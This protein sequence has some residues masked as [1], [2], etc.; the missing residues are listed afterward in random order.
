MPVHIHRITI[1]QISEDRNLHFILSSDKRAPED[2]HVGFSQAL[3]KP[4]TILTCAS[5]C[6]KIHTKLHLVEFHCKVTWISK[7]S[8]AFILRAQAHWECNVNIG[9]PPDCRALNRL[10][11]DTTP[12]SAKA[13]GRLVVTL[14]RQGC[15]HVKVEVSLEN[16]H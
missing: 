3:G 11:S 6:S 2:S 13:K 4:Q 7:L 12:H 16:S 14:T 8:T 9:Y 5:D 1:C 15:V 10:P